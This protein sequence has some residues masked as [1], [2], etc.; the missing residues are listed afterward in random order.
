MRGSVSFATGKNL[1]ELDGLTAEA[2]TI[3]LRLGMHAFKRKLFD[4]KT[5]SYVANL[6]NIL[7]ALNGNPLS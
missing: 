2:D 7:C 3:G 6:R 4:S 1:V 5:K